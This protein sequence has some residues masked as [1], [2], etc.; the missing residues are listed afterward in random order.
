MREEPPYLRLRARLP[1]WRVYEVVGAQPLLS[2]VGSG[3]GAASR[4]STPESFDLSVERAG[5]FVVRVRHTPYWDGGPRRLRGRGRG[6]DPGARAGARIWYACEPDSARSSLAGGARARRVSA[7]RHIYGVLRGF[8]CA[9]CDQ[10]VNF[11]L[12]VR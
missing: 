7:E 5:S 12:Q 1:H 9:V 10:V 8:S 6:L 4:G 2:Q 3:A 11:R